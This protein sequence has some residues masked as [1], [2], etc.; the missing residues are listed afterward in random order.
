MIN[1]EEIKAKILE[2]LRKKKESTPTEISRKLKIGYYLIVGIV[3]EM[4]EDKELE[5]IEYGT[6]HIHVRIFR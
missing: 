3:P 6:K 5:K 2:F 4:I 1:K